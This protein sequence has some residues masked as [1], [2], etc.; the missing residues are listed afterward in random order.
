[1][2]DNAISPV[3]GDTKA[4]EQTVKKYLSLGVTF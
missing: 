3:C 4:R 1:M 2:T